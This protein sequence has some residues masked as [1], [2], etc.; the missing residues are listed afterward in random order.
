MGTVVKQSPK[1]QNGCRNTN[2]GA[3]SQ[4]KSYSVTVW[5]QHGEPPKVRSVVCLQFPARG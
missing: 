2:P 1:R 5:L 4:N 3:D